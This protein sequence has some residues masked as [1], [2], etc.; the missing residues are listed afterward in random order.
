VKDD[1][2]LGKYVLAIMNSRLMTW[3]IRDVVFNRAYL[4]MHMDDPYLGQLPIKLIPEEEQKRTVTLVD[5]I[6]KLQGKLSKTKYTL[7]T[8]TEY[9]ETQEQ[10]RKLNKQIDEKVFDIYG[11]SASQR[12]LINQL[13]P[14]T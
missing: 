14:Y 3:Y 12:H 9:I 13:V 11:L 1:P 4:T 8:A 6:L 5:R 2:F 10:L 7:F